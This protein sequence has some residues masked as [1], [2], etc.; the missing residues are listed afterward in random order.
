MEQRAEPRADNPL[1]TKALCNQRQAIETAGAPASENPSRPAPRR[2]KLRWCSRARRGYAAR[3]ELG[4]VHAA[5]A[6]AFPPNSASWR[7]GA[8]AKCV[9]SFLGWWWHCSCESNA[10]YTTEG[11]HAR[12]RKERKE[13]WTRRQQS[14]R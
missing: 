14:R 10:H 11:E 9:P 4:V 12:T 3:W 8:D 13:S 2:P 5:S 7:R 6:F 1:S